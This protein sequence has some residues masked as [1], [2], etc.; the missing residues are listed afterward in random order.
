MLAADQ[1]DD[2]RK[3]GPGEAQQVPADDLV[4]GG[5]VGSRDAAPQPYASAWLRLRRTFFAASA[6]TAP[7]C[8]SAARRVRESDNEEGQV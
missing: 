2:M 7:S 1:P 5:I 4:M 8:W 3:R 6:M